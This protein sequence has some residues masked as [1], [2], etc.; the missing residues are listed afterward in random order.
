MGS[1]F[2]RSLDKP[3]G[4]LDHILHRSIDPA[5]DGMTRTNDMAVALAAL[6]VGKDDDARA[7]LARVRAISPMARALLH[8]MTSGSKANAYDAPRAF[9]VF[10]RGGGN[11]ALY[12]AV[13]TVLAE[14]YD[15][16]RPVDMID[17]GA[18]DG[19]A[20]LP[21]IEA[22]TYPPQK[23]DVVE[24]NSEMLARLCE[25]FPLNAGYNQT[26]EVFA[27]NLRSK[28]RWQLAQSTFALQSIPP[29]ARV[30][31]L[32]KLASHVERLVVIEFDIPELAP[33]SDALYESLA[34]RYDLAANE[35]GDDADLVASGFLAPM[36]LGQL[37]AVTPSNWEQPATA[38]VRELMTSGFREVEVEHVHDYS[39]APAVCI[40]AVP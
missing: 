29:D 17:I 30:K 3:C 24:P 22:A 16:Y 2:G 39:W 40:T 18:G 27:E 37:R 21:A 33:G 32:R 9:E 31:A 34:T 26:F 28:N 4:E 7:A 36:L 12:R 8:A 35:Q 38:R 25:A 13:S 14:T 19:M 20:L 15:R 11:V 10:I 23:V 1:T 5:V 6:A